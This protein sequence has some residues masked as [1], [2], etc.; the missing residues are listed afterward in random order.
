MI[1]NIKFAAQMRQQL[2]NGGVCVTEIS[3]K[4]GYQILLN[5]WIDINRKSEE[6]NFENSLVA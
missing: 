3:P 5:C 6:C 2:V 1:E 4:S